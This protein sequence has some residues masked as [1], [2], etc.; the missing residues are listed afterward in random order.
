MDLQFAHV[1]FF[2]LPSNSYLITFILMI[3]M[4]TTISL[5]AT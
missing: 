5:T 4:S 2:I 3:Y 1:F